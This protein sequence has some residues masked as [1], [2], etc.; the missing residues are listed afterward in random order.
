[1]YELVDADL[2][3][4]PAAHY[5]MAVALWNQH[6]AGAHNEEVKGW[7]VKAANWGFSYELDTRVGM[8]IQT[9]L[10]TINRHISQS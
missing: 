3:I 9:A 2:W 5:E 1:M 6:G 10:D 7:L 8:K 4:A